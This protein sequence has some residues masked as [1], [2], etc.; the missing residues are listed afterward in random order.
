VG[1]LQSADTPRSVDMARHGNIGLGTIGLGNTGLGNTGH[2][3][4]A[5]ESELAAAEDLG[6]RYGMG[7][8]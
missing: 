3:A 7:D 4:T 2:G 5:T 8:A 6:R 1:L